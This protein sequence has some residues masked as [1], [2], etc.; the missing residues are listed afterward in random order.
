V[1]AAAGT[2]LELK[3][4]EDFV[5]VLVSGLVSDFVSLFV[6]ADELS[7]LDPLPLDA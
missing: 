6:S 7:E 3:L 5:S 2:G 1:E 4:L